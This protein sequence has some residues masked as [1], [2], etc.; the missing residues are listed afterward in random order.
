MRRNLCWLVIALLVFTFLS[1]G[2]GGSSSSPISNNNTTQS[3]DVTPNNPTSPDNTPT[4]T[5]NTPTSP[6]NTPTTP[7]TPT[8]TYDFT[9]LSGT[10]KASNATGS[11]TAGTTTF[12]MTMNTSHANT[13]TF[14][15]VTAG[16]NLQ[17]SSQIYWDANGSGVSLTDI[18]DDLGG[19]STLTFQNISANTWQMYRTRSN[20]QPEITTIT[21][22]SSKTAKVE[23]DGYYDDYQNAHY[24]MSYTITKQ[25]DSQTTPTSPDNTPTTPNNNQT[26]TTIPFTTLEGTWK[27]SNGTGTWTGNGMSGTASLSTSHNNTI[28]FSNVNV[29]GNTATFEGTSQIYWDAYDQNG[30]LVQSD[31]EDEFGGHNMSSIG[32]EEYTNT[33]G[34]IWRMERLNKDNKTTRTIITFTSATTAQVE[35][36]EDREIQT[37]FSY[38]ITK[39]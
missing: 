26:T 32:G 37:S 18:H 38:I 19:S 29:S 14:S 8:T 20:G 5:P 22:T 3:Q 36:F 12:T 34:N 6:D 23:R 11:A 27:A 15:N 16:G 30:N 7:N 33:S 31:W 1:S 13:V 17:A 21:F 2:C 4:P 24:Q 25:S 9:I 39:Q 28:T 10:W 35:R